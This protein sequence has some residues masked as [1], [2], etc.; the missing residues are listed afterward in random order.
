[1]DSDTDAFI[2]DDNFEVICARMAELLSGEATDMPA[3]PQAASDFHAVGACSY[4]G[5]PEDEGVSADEGLAFYDDVMQAP[6]LFL[7]YQPDGTSGLARRLNPFVHYVACRWDYDQTPREMLRENTA[8]V[9]SLAN[10]TFARAFPADWGPHEKTGRIADLSPGLMDTLGINTD[11]EVEVIFP[12]K[13]D[14]S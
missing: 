14:F 8:L 7:P 6:Q 9:K 10:G 3:P 12:Y 2:Y 4:F 1:V 5:G 11:D 13:E